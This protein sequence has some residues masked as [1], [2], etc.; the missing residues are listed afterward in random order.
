LEEISVT[1]LFFIVAFVIIHFVYN[2]SCL[3]S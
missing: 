1:F 2:Q 3:E